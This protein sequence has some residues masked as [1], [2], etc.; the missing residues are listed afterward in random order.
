MTSLPSLFAPAMSWSWVWALAATTNKCSNRIAIN[1]DFIH[2]PVRGKVIDG[3]ASCQHA[4]RIERV[5]KAEFF[6]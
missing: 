5:D 2:S 3:Y 1:D 6:H 4:G